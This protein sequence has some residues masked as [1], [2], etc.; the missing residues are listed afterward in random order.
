[1]A[2]VLRPKVDAAVHLHELTADTELAAF[3]LFSSVAALIGS[4]GQGNYA[5]AN[6]TLDALA[7]HRRATGLP[8]S[9]L[10]WG[11]WADATGMTGDLGEA[12]LARLARMGIGAL[13]A[14]L[15]LELFDQA[16]QLDEALLVP[17]Q[18]DQAALRVQAGAGMLPALLRGLI[19]APARRADSGG[20]SLAE[21]LAGV[22]QPDWERVTLDLVRAQVA[23]VLGHASPDAIDPDRAF[24]EL[25]F[26]SLGAVE[27]RNRLTRATGLRL[28]TTLVFDHP[29]PAAV[30][31]YLIPVAMPGAATNGHRPSEEDEIRAVL[32]SI[33]LA[34]LREAGLLDSLVELAKGDPDGGSSATA[35]ESIDDMDAEALIRMSQED[36]A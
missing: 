5:A 11:L 22:P 20:G 23:S 4:P 12:E 8:A 16:R 32:A 13:P 2:R 14:E 15:G 21:R 36:V 27:L 6:A 34:R 19:R 31:R 35:T 25:G 18:L 24:K 10:A 28:P 30:A 26:D 33:P 9:S 7:A 3:V 29:T 17:V 1:M